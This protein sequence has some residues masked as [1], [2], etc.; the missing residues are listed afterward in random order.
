MRFTEEEQR[1]LECLTNGMTFEE[2]AA[3]LGWSY[4]EV[5][6]FGERFFGR[7]F[8]ARSKED[9]V[10]G[11]LSQECKRY[12]LLLMRACKMPGAEELVRLYEQTGDDEYRIAF[13]HMILDRL[14]ERLGIGAEL[15]NPHSD[16]VL[17]EKR[18]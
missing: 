7:D 4:R 17:C 10:L 9:A 13:A 1:Y 5:V 6:G 11:Q 15:D 14:I 18:N 2:M 16:S 12:R 3:K 8:E